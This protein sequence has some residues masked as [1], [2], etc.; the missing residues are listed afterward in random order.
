M[1]HYLK[2]WE[3]LLLDLVLHNILD[4]IMMPKLTS[5]I[6]TWDPCKETMPIHAQLHPW[7]P[8]LGQHM[9]PLYPTIHYKLGNALHSWHARDASTYAIL[10]P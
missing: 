6:Y 7:L 10:S 8:F 5:A 1:L 4:H 3:K 9:E 2:R